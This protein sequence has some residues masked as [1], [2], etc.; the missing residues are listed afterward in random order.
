MDFKIAVLAGDGIGPEISA[1]GVDVMTAVCEKFGHKVSYE[2]AI[3]GAHAIDEVGDPFPEAT[4]Q[5]CQKAD[6][7]LFSAVGDPKFDNNPTAKVRPEQG[8]LAMRKKL[9]LFAN[10]R[11]V[12]TF[13]CLLHKS[14]LRAELVDGADFLCIRELTG[15]MYF[16]YQK[17]KLKKLSGTYKGQ[18]MTT[19]EHISVATVGAAGLTHNNG[20]TYLIE[21]QPVGVFYL[22]HCTGIDENGQYI[23]ED[24]DDN[25]TIDTGDSGD[26]KVCGQAIPK[27]FL[28]WD[29]SFKYKNWD[30]TMQFNGAFGHKIYNATSMTL[31]NM[32]NFPTYN[33]LSGAQHLNNGK[34]IHD[35]QISDYW[36]E[37]GDYMNFEYASLG[38]TFTKDM[39]KWKFI[40]NIH[41]SLSVNNI[42]TL[43]GY[44]GLT[45]MINSA[46]ISG[47]NLGIDDKNIYP[48]SRTYTLSLSVNF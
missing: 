26:R 35:V 31:N 38:Y 19:S 21:G 13:K 48:L 15:G 22:P 12:Q 42:C 29:M 20:V 3:C 7:V 34:G 4:F 43:T 9:G 27:Y 25:G 1:V 10:I 32:S 5:A 36:L 16:S 39:L 40:N 46:T 6:A 14:P 17:N 23:I 8:L 41:L 33:I 11:P 18:P 24:L 2:Y 37:K 30:L 44:K 28:G 45:P 47:D